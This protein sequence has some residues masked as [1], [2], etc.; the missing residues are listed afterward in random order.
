[1]PT[2]RI[3]LAQ[4]LAIA[5]LTVSGCNSQKPAP[6]AP[7]P[8]AIELLPAAKELAE[9]AHEKYLSAETQ[10]AQIDRLIALARQRGHDQSSEELKQTRS[11]WEKMR[12]EAKADWDKAKDRVK[13]LAKEALR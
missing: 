11:K 10:I 8:T 1:M 4:S 9:D 2:G 7:K 5:A 6:P 13:E 12:S 3:L